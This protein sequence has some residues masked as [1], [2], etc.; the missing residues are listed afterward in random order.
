MFLS[1]LAHIKIAE[2]LKTN[3]SCW[4]SVGKVGG[5]QFISLGYG[6]DYL[7]TVVHETGHALGFWHEQVALIP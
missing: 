7:G 2:I 5:E 1:R 3:F 4:S 6:C